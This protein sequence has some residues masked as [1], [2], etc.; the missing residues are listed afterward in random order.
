MAGGSSKNAAPSMNH[1]T[2]IE[3]QGV[4]IKTF[5]ISKRCAEILETFNGLP[6]L[7]REG[8]GRAKMK[9]QAAAGR[10]S[11]RGPSNF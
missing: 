1:Y 10:I 8:S 2:K 6:P 7:T 3:R 5:K 4:S 9:M 11:W